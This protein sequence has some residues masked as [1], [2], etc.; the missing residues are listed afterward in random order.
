MRQA[1]RD[2]EMAH[3]LNC[4][5]DGCVRCWRVETRELNR[6]SRD[7][8][9]AARATNR[10]TNWEAVAIFGLLLCVG[11]VIASVVVFAATTPPHH[12][13]PPTL[14]PPFESSPRP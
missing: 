6:A 14:I 12:F 5:R 10:S 13:A 11:L 2:A 9:R 1:I 3:Y 4:H 8:R 7:P